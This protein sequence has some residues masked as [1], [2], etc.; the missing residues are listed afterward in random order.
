MMNRPMKVIAVNATRL[1]PG[2]RPAINPP[3]TGMESSRVGLVSTARNGRIEPTETTS[4]SA[5]TSI[6]TIVPN[7]C[8]RRRG[9]KVRYKARSASPLLICVRLVVASFMRRLI[10]SNL[11][12]VHPLRPMPGWIF[13]VSGHQTVSRLA[14]LRWGKR[15]GKCDRLCRRPGRSKHCACGAKA[16][17]FTI[18]I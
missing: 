1:V 8:R 12:F 10:E 9:D 6:S 13:I 4:A 14:C 16:H 18:P 17:T 2:G 3:T 5:P 7:A 15:V 11:G